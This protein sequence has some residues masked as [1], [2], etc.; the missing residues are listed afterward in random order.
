MVDGTSVV[1]IACVSSDDGR[2]LE[3]ALKETGSSPLRVCGAEEVTRR[4]DEDFGHGAVLLIDAGL[5][6]MPH[7]P[8]WRD[9]CALRP[10]LGTVVRRLR[11]RAEP[12]AAPDLRTFEVYPDDLDGIRW[13]VRRLNG[14]R[15]GRAA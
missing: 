12:P 3:R 11:P 7:D 15:P 14:G 13:A 4:I 6:Q 8:Q 10:D 1:M 5:L 2:L 9:L